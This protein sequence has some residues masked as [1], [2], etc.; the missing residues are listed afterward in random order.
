MR[1]ISCLLVLIVLLGGSLW[2][3]VIKT[4]ELELRIRGYIQVDARSY[5]GQE[6][7]GVDTILLRR[8]RPV[9]EAIIHKD[10]EVRLMPDFA[11]D[12]AT[13]YDAYINWRIRPSLQLLVGKVKAPVGLER[14][15]SATSLMF[16]ERGLPTAVVPNR[17]TGIEI[18]GNI[19]TLEYA[20][21]IFNGALD[22]GSAV[23]DTDNGKD[24]AARVFFCP[25]GVGVGVAGTYGNHRGG[26]PNHYRTTGQQT[27]FRFANGTVNDGQLWRVSPQGYYYQGPL[28]ILA[29]WVTSSQELLNGKARRKAHVQSYQIT[30]GYVITGEA[31]SYRGVRPKREFHPGEGAWGALEIVGRVGNLAVGDDVFPIFAK[32]GESARGANNLGVGANWYPNKSAKFSVNCEKT[33]LD[34]L[35]DEYLL[36]GRAQL[37]F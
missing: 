9:L 37:V 18:H 30:T 15:Q 23:V 28:G 4:P 11:G 16:L 27:F 6:L 12:T 3:Q 32:L 36:S 25:K 20:V 26:A 17:D 31:N 22:G 13:L 35:P 19:K 10:F 21:G 7:R 29:E 24:I 8:A 2:G 1:K 33:W 34:G 14:L 5:L